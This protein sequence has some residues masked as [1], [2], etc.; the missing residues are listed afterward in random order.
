MDW[1]AAFSG[2]FMIL[3]VSSKSI[4]AYGFSIWIRDIGECEGLKVESNQI[5]I[6]LLLICVALYEI[7]SHDTLIR[8]VTVDNPKSVGQCNR[9][10]MDV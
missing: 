1:F 2:A 6:P 5:D 10:I 9:D 3:A 7:R 4:S 8:F